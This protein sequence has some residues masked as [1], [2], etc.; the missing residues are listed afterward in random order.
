MIN[1]LDF[2]FWM[3][4]ARAGSNRK[5]GINCEGPNVGFIPVPHGVLRCYTN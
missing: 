1:F 5:L 4:A 2:Q 3:L